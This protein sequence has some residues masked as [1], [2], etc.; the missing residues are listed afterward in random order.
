MN[1][2]SSGRAEVARVILDR[3]GVKPDT[4]TTALAAAQRNDHTEL[5]LILEEAGANRQEI[6]T[7]HVGLLRNG[8][9]ISSLVFT[10]LHCQSG[11][12]SGCRPDI[13]DIRD[14]VGDGRTQLQE[15]C[16][17]GC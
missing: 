8:L 10:S 1:A 14:K 16:G 6:S 7:H 15:A 12:E 9:M 17:N 3:G 4:L 13:S 5:A 11:W 2:V